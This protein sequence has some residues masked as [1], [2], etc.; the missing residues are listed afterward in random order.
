MA[1]RWPVDPDQEDGGDGGGRY[2][3]NFSAPLDG[4][5]AKVAQLDNSSLLRVD[6]SKTA[7][8]LVECD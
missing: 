1:S 8:S 4:Q 7:E 6:C 5:S 2:T 3:E